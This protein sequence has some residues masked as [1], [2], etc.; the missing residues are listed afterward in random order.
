MMLGIGSG[1]FGATVFML[2]LVSSVL[3]P[4]RYSFFNNR[5]VP[6]AYRPSPGWAETRLPGLGRA[7]LLPRD[8]AGRRLQAGGGPICSLI[9]GFYRDSPRSRPVTI[10]I[11]MARFSTRRAIFC[12]RIFVSSGRQG[13]SV[14]S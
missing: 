6:L 7:A 2:D 3:K 10:V 1:A 11:V 14:K 4:D 8:R 9:L 13:T 12:P 5:A